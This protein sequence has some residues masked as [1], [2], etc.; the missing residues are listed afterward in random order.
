MSTNRSFPYLTVQQVA[1]RLGLTTGRIRQLLLEG[2]IRGRKLGS[3]QWMILR[4]E[5]SR[6]KKN[7]ASAQRKAAG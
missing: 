3:R 6:H 5:V 2:K 1:D 4:S 7:R